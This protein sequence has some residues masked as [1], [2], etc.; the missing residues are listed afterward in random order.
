MDWI[1]IV[2]LAVVCLVAFALAGVS[3]WAEAGSLGKLAQELGLAFDKHGN[4]E[5]SAALDALG[6]APAEPGQ[7]PYRKMLHGAKGRVQFALF[8]LSEWELRGTVKIRVIESM[9]LYC[10]S[11]DL[12]LPRM[13][14]VPRALA[15]RFAGRYAQRC[16]ATAAA[17]FAQQFEV[18]ADDPAAATAVLNEAVVQLFLEHPQAVLLGAGNQMAIKFDGRRVPENQ[19]KGFLREALGMCSTWIKASRA[20]G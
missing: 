7:Q 18:L 20:A 19:W 5:I 12:R 16:A 1:A 4:P 10:Q 9:G 17:A 11:V 15:E 14:I 6:L 3:I 2:V 8:E 13:A